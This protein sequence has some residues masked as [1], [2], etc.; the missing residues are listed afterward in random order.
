LSEKK[1]ADGKMMVFCMPD[2]PDTEAN[3]KD[4]N[5]GCKE[6]ENTNDCKV[7]DD[8]HERVKFAR[9]GM[10]PWECMPK[11]KYKCQNGERGCEKC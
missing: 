11:D 6:C 4:G 2:K 5:K 8:A 9:E 10:T 7:C 3:C 1:T